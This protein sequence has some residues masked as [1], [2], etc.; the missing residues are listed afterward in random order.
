MCAWLLLIC[1]SRFRL[2]FYPWCNFIFSASHVHAYFMHTYSFFLFV[3]FVMCFL[4]ISL[5]RINSRNF[6]PSSFLE[7]VLIASRSIKKLSVYLIDSPQL[8]D[9]SRYLRHRQILDTTLTDSLLSG[10]RAWQISISP[11]SIKPCFS[12][13]AWGVIWF[14]FFH[15]S[16]DRN[17]L[18]Q[19]K[20]SFSLLNLLTHSIFA[21]DQDENTW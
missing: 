5:S 6:D 15:F 8:L 13:H 19:P 7:F 18:S 3:L 17:F 12:I 20:K 4:S 11:R 10:F 21:L 14:S 16:L 2:A 9:A 1:A